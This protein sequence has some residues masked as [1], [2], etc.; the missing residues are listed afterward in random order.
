VPTATVL[1]DAGDV[2]VRVGA[3]SSA[4]AKAHVAPEKA[5]LA[6]SSMHPG[7]SSIRYAVSSTSADV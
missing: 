4:V 5:L 6:R 3:V 1:P 7:A 2:A